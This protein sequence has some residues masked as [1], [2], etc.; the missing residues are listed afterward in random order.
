MY[1]AVMC[2]SKGTVQSN[3]HN[4][5]MFFSPLLQFHMPVENVIDKNTVGGNQVNLSKTLWP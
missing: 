1:Y 2:N 3:V 5:E 4:V